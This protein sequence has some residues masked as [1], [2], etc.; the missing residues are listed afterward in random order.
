[1]EA[2]TVCIRMAKR[3]KISR[4]KQKKKEEKRISPGKVSGKTK[5][6]A[7]AAAAAAAEAATAEEDSR[8]KLSLPSRKFHLS[9]ALD[10]PRKIRRGY[11]SIPGKFNTR[12]SRKIDFEAG[13]LNERLLKDKLEDPRKDDIRAKCLR[14]DG[15]ND[16]FGIECYRKVAD[17][18]RPRKIST[19]RPPGRNGT[20]C[21][22]E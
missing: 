5:S 4:A 11:D 12:K 22:P 8:E 16:E 14:P 9:I 13:D 1:M 10:Y 2:L 17:V 7:A 19:L 15:R 20:G 6:A 18:V 3:K 21:A